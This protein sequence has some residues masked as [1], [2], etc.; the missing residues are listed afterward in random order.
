MEAQDD[1]D[2]R[3]LWKF[4]LIKSL[5][6]KNFSRDDIMNLY[7]FIDWLIT[8]PEKLEIQLQKDVSKLE[9]E[10]KMPHVTSAERIGIKKGKEEIARKMLEDGMDIKLI[11][12]YTG[13]SVEEIR[14]IKGKKEKET[15]PG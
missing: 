15:L 14:D 13:L 4:S 7:G 8:L 3:R 12:R 10:M 5:Y 11:A 6:H 9:E 1:Y 2:K